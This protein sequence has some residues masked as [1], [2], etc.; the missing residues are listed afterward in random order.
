MPVCLE[1]LL[2]LLLVPAPA[3]V[4]WASA[5]GMVEPPLAADL[6]LPRPLRRFDV[7]D[8]GGKGDGVFLNTDAFEAAVAAISAANGGE[9]YVGRGVWVTTGFALVSHMSLFLDHGA[10]LLGAF[11]NNTRWRPRND[12]CSSYPPVYPPD[13]R[14]GAAHTEDR[15]TGVDE[16]NSGC[17]LQC[18]RHR[19][20]VIWHEWV[21]GVEVPGGAQ[22]RCHLTV[23][24]DTDADAPVCAALAGTV[25]FLRIHSGSSQS[26]AGGI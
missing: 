23:F 4:P 12:S 26:S 20:M 10:T 21:R 18:C 1:L 16:R 9:L 19:V 2:L 14:G 7:A 22:H 11:P 17:A 5:D 6:R 8:F 25:P 13:C 15:G 24:A 3:A